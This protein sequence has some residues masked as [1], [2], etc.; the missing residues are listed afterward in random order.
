MPVSIFDKFIISF[1]TSQAHYEK[2][3]KLAKVGA[4]IDDL[5]KYLRFC[6]VM[7]TSMPMDDS[8]FF[9]ENLDDSELQQYLTM[10]LYYQTPQC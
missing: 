3:S 8:E 6:C 2:V 1:P 10:L 4:E 5:E 9:F 7:L